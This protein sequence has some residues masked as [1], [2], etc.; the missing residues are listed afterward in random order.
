MRWFPQ[1][2]ARASGNAQLAGNQAGSR[3]SR[4]GGE[5]LGLLPICRHASQQCSYIM[6][7]L[8]IA[9]LGKRTQCL[10]HFWAYC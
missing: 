3:V 9:P 4:E 5:G 7:C 2:I 6:K 1:S 8:P 10:H